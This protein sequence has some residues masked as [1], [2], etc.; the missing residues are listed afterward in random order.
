M[1]GK[2]MRSQPQP[3]NTIA[4]LMLANRA[5]AQELPHTTTTHG[6]QT[7]AGRPSTQGSQTQGSQH[8]QGTQTHS[9]Q[10]SQGSSPQA[11]APMVS[12]ADTTQALTNTQTF[13]PPPSAPWL[14]LG[15]PSG[16]PPPP[17]TAMVPSN[18]N[19]SMHNVGRF[20]LRYANQAMLNVQGKLTD[21]AYGTNH[22]ALSAAM[23]GRQLTLGAYQIALGGGQVA[24]RTAQRVRKHRRL[25]LEGSTAQ[26]TQPK[27]VPCKFIML[28]PHKH[29]VH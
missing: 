12:P 4:D 15:Y 28:R 26:N 14:P 21:I 22:F 27:T 9:S 2:M 11:S 3:K 23:G 8:T 5:A 25:A 18:S 19:T 7:E 13:I 29:T 24:I 1:D 10:G 20:A 16:A 6:T 17:Q